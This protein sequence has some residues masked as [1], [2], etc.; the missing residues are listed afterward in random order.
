MKFEAVETTIKEHQGNSPNN[1][2]KVFYLN[3]DNFEQVTNM[4]KYKSS[5]LKLPNLCFIDSLIHFKFFK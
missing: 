5:K 1:S 2:Q 4:S 3:D